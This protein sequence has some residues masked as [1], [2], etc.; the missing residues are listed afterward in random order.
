MKLLPPPVVNKRVTADML[1]WIMRQS[2]T[3]TMNTTTNEFTITPGK[4]AQDYPIDLMLRVIMVQE[5]VA[6]LSYNN[7]TAYEQTNHS[8]MIKKG[9][10]SFVIKDILDLMPF[11]DY[12]PA[13]IAKAYEQ[14]QYEIDQ[15]YN[16]RVHGKD[17]LYPYEPGWTLDSP[18]QHAAKQ[19]S[20]DDVF[21]EMVKYG[22]T[23][24]K[25]NADHSH[26]YPSR[27][28]LLEIRKI[29]EDSIDDTDKD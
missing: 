3:V 15:E 24:M 20:A 11:P 19:Q 22:M 13:N 5:L 2:N 21:S 29:V 1:H 28:H 12:L 9:G 10:W 6:I 27:D 18:V 16:A 4:G 23:T 17:H 7:F 26:N 14:Y 8:L 25:V